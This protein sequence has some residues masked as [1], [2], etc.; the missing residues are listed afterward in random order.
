MHA[1]RVDERELARRGVHLAEHLARDDRLWPGQLA[2]LG[3]LLLYA[4][5]PQR[6]A[7]GPNGLLPAAE[8]AALVVLV[9]ATRRDLA[10]GLRRGLTLGLLVVVTVTN[11]VSLGLLVHYLLEGGHARGADLVAGGVLI[12]STNLLLFAVWFWWIDRGGPLNA[13]GSQPPGLP[14]LLFPPMTDDR[15]AAPGWTPDFFDYLFVSLTNQSAFSPTDTL[16]LTLRVKLLMGIQA[17]A[18]LVTFGVIIARAVN[19][20]GG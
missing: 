2:I 9:V 13:E 18:A 16:P 17:T 12:W 20:L 10:V 11:L 19:V 14:D 6:L 15:Y 3:C 8:L 5:L 4:L 1:V 7:F